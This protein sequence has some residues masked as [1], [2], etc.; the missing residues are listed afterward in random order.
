VGST[1]AVAAPLRIVAA[2]LTAAGG[3][4]AVVGLAAAPRE[5]V[6]RVAAGLACVVVLTCVVW[7][8]FSYRPGRKRLAKMADLL[9]RYEIDRARYERAVRTLVDRALSRPIRETLKTVYFIGESPEQDS[10]LQKWE[11]AAV[12]PNKPIAWHY[13]QAAA[14]GQ[15]VPRKE[16]FRQLE[17][18]DAWETVGSGE[19]RRLQPLAVGAWAE[20][21][22]G[23]VFF[24]TEITV[25]P[26]RRWRLQYQWTGAWNC[27]RANLQ[28][29]C[30]VSLREDGEEVTW[31]LLEV[32]FV[33]PRGAQGIDIA[34][35]EPM[36]APELDVDEQGRQHFTF[37]VERPR[38][39]VYSWRITVDSLHAG[40]SLAA[41]SAP[42]PRTSDEPM[43]PDRRVATQHR[44]QYEEKS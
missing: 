4:A 13:V 9:E 10:T 23:L 44:E 26:A 34:A 11:T 19:R 16:S 24:N 37:H 1:R 17:G 36:A 25:G 27:L 28:D 7:W 31:E 18:V 20:R 22:W 30:W 40:Q 33:F 42:T 3:I 32:E 41:A 8:A 21:L 6:L 14:T 35:S 29:E 2:V 5:S 43:G 38:H 12:D 15:G 39:I